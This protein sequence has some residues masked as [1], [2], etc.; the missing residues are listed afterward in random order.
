MILTKIRLQEEHPMTMEANSWP[1]P[2][3]DLNLDISAGSNGYVI[4]NSQGLGPPDLVS[5]VEGW[6][7]NGVPVMNSLAERRDIVLRIGT[8]PGLGQTHNELRDDLYKLISR[9]VLVKFMNDA[10]VTAQAKGFVS[11]FETVHFTNQPE[12]QLTIECRDGDLVSPM[13]I[14]IPFASLAADSP[15]INYSEGTAQ[16]GLDLQFSVD[17]SVAGFSFSEFGKAWHLGTEDVHNLFHVTYPLIA[18]DVITLGTTTRYKRLTLLRGVVEYDLAGYINPGA[19][20]PKLYPGVNIFDWD[21]TS[22]WMTWISASYTPRY[23]GV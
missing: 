19:V 11:K 20:W 15:I 16:T 6:D 5:V 12:V 1:L 18:D 13:A 7:I 21:I 2:V 9:S 3:C 23:W 10:E 8:R 17:S 22:T 4:K 14:D